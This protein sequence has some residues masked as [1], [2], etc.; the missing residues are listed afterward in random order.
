[1]KRIGQNILGLLAMAI[2]L[3]AASGPAT[4]GCDWLSVRAGALDRRFYQAKAASMD[5]P[6]M[7]ADL[8]ARNEKLAACLLADD[9]LRCYVSVSIVL[10]RYGRVQ[11]G[12][13]F[14]GPG[15]ADRHEHRYR[16]GVLG[17]EG[18]KAE[19]I[20]KVDELVGCLDLGSF[21]RLYV[22]LSLVQ[23]EYGLGRR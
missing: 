12:W 14:Q 16:G 19:F 10:G 9:Y 11:C 17:L 1:M 21:R 4:A 8:T 23:D 3:L 2:C 13:S 22:E 5:G 18:M 6:Q 15:S 20:S 7:V